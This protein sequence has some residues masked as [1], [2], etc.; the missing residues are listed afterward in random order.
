MTR[1][2]KVVLDPE[3][4]PKCVEVAI[5]DVESHDLIMKKRRQNQLKEIRMA[6]KKALVPY[7]N[8]DDDVKTEALLGFAHLNF[9][10]TILPWERMKKNARKSMATLGPMR[11]PNARRAVNTVS[12]CLMGAPGSDTHVEM[13]TLNRCLDMG[14]ERPLFDIR[15]HMADEI[16][17]GKC[18][19]FDNPNAKYIFT[20]HHPKNIELVEKWYFS[21]F[22]SIFLNFRLFDCFTIF[23]SM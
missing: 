14:M 20:K 1:R 19:S 16:G 3:W 10:N 6:L 22:C 12:A 15:A 8:Y 9:D 13:T 2:M 5:D 18:P 17:E 4:A 11:N 23:S 21:T 7:D